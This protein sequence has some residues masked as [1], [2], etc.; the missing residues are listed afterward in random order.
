MVSPLHYSS[1]WVWFKSSRYLLWILH[2]C[3]YFILPISSFSRIFFHSWIH[4][5]AMQTVDFSLSLFH[6]FSHVCI[7]YQTLHL[8]FPLQLLYPEITFTYSV[9]CT[10]KIQNVFSTHFIGTGIPDV[11]TLQTYPQLCHIAGCCWNV[12]ASVSSDDNNLE[13]H[14]FLSIAASRMLFMDFRATRFTFE[15]EESCGSSSGLATRSP[16]VVYGHD[17]LAPGMVF[18]FYQLIY[19]VPNLQTNCHLQL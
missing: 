10:L 18:Q 2:W 16:C 4:Q 13:Q 15:A 14:N 5:M 7:H 6:A 19:T 3:L 12:V 8:N 17:L 11:I 9:L 1:I